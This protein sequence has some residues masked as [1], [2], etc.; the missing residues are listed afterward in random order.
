MYLVCSFRSLN[1]LSLPHPNLLVQ[2]LLLISE[3]LSE[4]LIISEMTSS[5]VILGC[6]SL[7]SAI[8]PATMGDENDV[9]KEVDEYAEVELPDVHVGVIML[10]DP[11]AVSVISSPQLLK[12]ACVS[13]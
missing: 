7:R 3:V 12:D 10:P 9:P 11:G 4:E 8:V 6:L 1:A 13:A 2:V 5:V